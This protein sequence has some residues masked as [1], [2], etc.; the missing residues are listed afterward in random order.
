MEVSITF[1]FFPMINLLDITGDDVAKLNDEDLRTLIGRLCEADYRLK[2]YST[3]G[4]TWGGNQNARD[5]GLDV[6]VRDTLPPPPNSFIP[7]SVTGFQV[8]ITNMTVAKIKKEI[9]PRGILR[10]EIINLV[11]EN[12]AYII[13]SSG[14]STTEPSLNDR[15]A[16][17][18]KTLQNV[19][20]A[21]NLQLDFFD[22]GRVATWLRLHPSL[23]LWVRN[24]I[25]RPLQGWKPFANWA[26]PQCELEEEYEI[27]K[28][29]RVHEGNSNTNSGMSV[30]DGVQS[31]RSALSIPG[32]SIRLI[33]L[34]GVGKTRFVQA[35]FDEKIGKNPLNRSFVFYTDISFSPN[36]NPNNIVEQLIAGKARTILIVD[37]CDPD[38]HRRLSQTTSQ[39][40]SPISLLTIEYDV[41]DDLPEET[42]VYKLEAASE[43]IIEKL[44]QKRFKYISQVDAKTIAKFSGGNFRLAITLADTIQKGETLS[45]FRD[46]DLFKRLFYQRN[47]PNDDLLFSGAVCS[48]VY[49]FEG[50]DVDSEKSELNF[51]ASFIEKSGSELFRDIAALKERGLVQSRDKWRAILPHALANRLAKQA[52][53]FIPKET[54][55]NSFMQK[56]SE[57][58]IKSFS[59]RLNYL[60]DCDKAIE[61]VNDWLAKDGWIGKELTHLNTFGMEVFQNIAPVSLEKTLEII[62][63]A[64]N[65]DERFA[66]GENPH[67]KEFLRILWHLAYDP[68]L[69]MRSVNILC[70]F[71]LHQKPEATS[72]SASEDLLALFSIYLSGTLAPVEERAKFI[73]ELINSGDQIKQEIAILLLN[74]ALSTQNFHSHTEFNFGAR[75]RNYGYWPNTSEEIAHWYETFL[76]I[77]TSLSISD[78]PIAPKARKI[79]SDNLH[80][81]WTHAY[82]HEA[83]ENSI[84][85]IHEH[86]AWNE[87]WIAIKGIIKNDSAVFSKGI[88][89]KL[90]KIESVLKPK[91]LVERARTF[92]L[93]KNYGIFTLEEDFDDDNNDPSAHLSEMEETTR[94]IGLQVI[95]DSDTLNALLPEL[96]STEYTPRLYCFG[97]GLADGCAEK[98]KI[99]SVFRSQIEKTPSG[100]RQI[101][102]LLGFLSS[103]AEKDP[104]FYN[105]TLDNLV[106][107]DLLGEW[108]PS[109]QATSRIDKQGVE[110]LHKALDSGKVK[111][112]SFAILAWGRNH[113]SISDDD[114][115]DLLNKILSKEDG[116][117]VVIDI[118]HMRFWGQK[119][120]AI[121]YSNK[122]FKVAHVV[123]S[124][125]PF[126]SEK[127]IYNRCDYEL[128]QIAR[129][130]LIGKRNRSAAL[131]ICQHFAAAINEDGF[132]LHDC[133]DLLNVLADSHPTVF[134]DVFLGENVIKEYQ[135]RISLGHSFRRILKNPMNKISDENLISWCDISPVERYPLVSSAI[136]AF[137]ES[138]ESKELKWKPIV[139][140]IFSKAPDLNVVFVNIAD[141]I[142]PTIW[143]ENLSAI[144]QK[145]SSLFLSLFQHDNK[146]IRALAER[147]YFALQERIKSEKIQE[148][149]LFKQIERFE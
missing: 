137:A 136:D 106:N 38:L 73:E 8:K 133:C 47:S 118:L 116:V 123:L 4:I 66:S 109:F 49:S 61:I 90:Y 39:P 108:L 98:Q 79:L 65:G 100:K 129:E 84:C 83:L 2:G 32:N 112:N 13:V 17:M 105:S 120:K 125:Y 135:R 40:S 139:G 148:R 6:V 82:I 76:N 80:G 37:N 140:S 138:A 91:N 44:M 18:K 67:E 60:H 23:I 72:Y 21:D 58:L 33:G 97:Q 99:W 30:E 62:E 107:D 71:A 115:A 93:S 144:L 54:L 22:R 111:I 145:R 14:A 131:L 126:N 26:H 48:L 101:G 50:I 42:N 102:A 16:A 134:L 1:V 55:K 104:A 110:R 20:N 29:I 149:K 113:E 43:E 78:L 34:S 70:R 87:G 57:R 3:K 75:S 51:L 85:K 94:K 147:K 127:K 95:Q 77:S 53:E 69:F 92:A 35:L 96:F 88:L 124:T 143:N 141:S 64:A 121:N 103:C 11:K 128:S 56:G 52:L 89:E 27:D 28:N 12:G 142:I 68:H 114:L 122:L 24:K 146:E 41:R 132:F 31:L 130:C 59:H 15:I 81:L 45:G 5:G 86:Q 7:R 117:N 19:T 36:P 74:T 9:C 10:N 63:H 119:N 25:G 46:A